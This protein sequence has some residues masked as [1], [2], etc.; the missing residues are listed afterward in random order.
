[1]KHLLGKAKSTKVPFL[2]SEV[3]VNK[4]TVAQVKQFQAELN[5][6]K[7]VVDEDSGLKIQR[8]IVRM[9]VVG[10]AD[11]TDEE[12]DSFPLVELTALTQKILELAGVAGA[13]TEG[14]ASPKKT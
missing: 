8:T 4:L 14:N 2:G 5:A 11:L 7:D 3:E 6:V 12:L 1:M 9:G 10:A 13:S